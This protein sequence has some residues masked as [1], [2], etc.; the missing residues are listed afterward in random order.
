MG[1]QVTVGSTVPSW[2]YADY[3]PKADEDKMQL[4]AKSWA[5]QATAC[6][7]AAESLGSTMSSLGNSYT[8]PSAEKAQA[9]ATRTR[10]WIGSTADACN[11]LSGQVK[12]AAEYVLF[13]KR[14]MNVVLASLQAATQKATTQAK[15]NVLQQV[16]VA[17]KVRQMQIAARAQIRALNVACVNKIGALTATVDISPDMSAP[18]PAASGSYG[19][20][21]V[22]IKATF[23]SG[24][25]TGLA[26]K[27]D[28]TNA[29][30]TFRLG[31][32]QRTSPNGSL[33][34]GSLSAG[35]LPGGTMPGGTM[36]GGHPGQPGDLTAPAA[37]DLS[38]AD[39]VGGNGA[40]AGVD[41]PPDALGSDGHGADGRRPD[42]TSDPPGILPGGAQVSVADR[43]AADDAVVTGHSHYDAEQAG[44]TNAAA[45]T[46]PG[47]G[48]PTPADTITQAD[49]GGH[50]R[51]D[52]V[53]PAQ[54]SGYQAPPEAPIPTSS[55][56]PSQAP[57]QPAPTYTPAQSTQS[58]TPTHP[59]SVPGYS[60]SASSSTSSNSGSANFSD[61]SYSGGSR[62]YSGADSTSA[63]APAPVPAPAP[64]P[65][66][67]PVHHEPAGTHGAGT[68]APSQP[69]PSQP[70]PTVPSD[71]S[72]NHQPSQGAGNQPSQGA[73]NAVGVSDS[74]AAGPGSNAPGGPSSSGPPS[75]A[76]PSA[77]PPSAAP[78]GSG[79]PVA[80]TG[81]PS[82]PASVGGPI[83]GS[84]PGPAGPSAPAAASAGTS[85]PAVSGPSSSG[86]A[87]GGAP[88]G[89]ATGSGPGGSSGPAV[90]PGSSPGAAPTSGPVGTGG[91][92]T[93][94][95]SGQGTHGPDTHGPGTHGPGTH[96]PDSHGPGTAGPGTEGP[97]TEGPAD[98]TD[99]GPGGDV[100]TTTGPR[101]DQ[102]GVPPGVDQPDAAVEAPIQRDANEPVSPT[103]AD[104]GQTHGA[105][106]AAQSATGLLAVGGLIG[107]GS[108]WADLGRPG[109]GG[110]PSGAGPHGGTIWATQFGAGDQAT[111]VLPAGLSVTYQKVL[112]PSET[113]RFLSLRQRSLRG[114]IYPLD[115][116][117]QL[118][119]PAEL[120]GKLGL[121]FT[122]R[123]G[124]GQPETA[125]PATA[126]HIDVLRFN[127]IRDEDL[128][129]PVEADV[130]PPAQPQIPWVV[131]LHAR[132]W[133]GNGEAPGSLST[134]IIEEFELLAEAG[135]AVPH[136][137][138]IWR[139]FANGE[140]EHVST[141]NARA[142]I[143][144]GD[145]QTVDVGGALVA[146]GM[147]AV[148]TEG[149]QYGAVMVNDHEHVLTWPPRVLVTG[150]EQAGPDG[151]MRIA[152]DNKVLT[153]LLGVATLAHWQ[154][155]RVRL[156]R[157]Y[158]GKSMIDYVGGDPAEAAQ[159]GFRQLGQGE[160]ETRWVPADQVEHRTRMEREYPMP[161]AAEQ[162]AGAIS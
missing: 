123:D 92:P 29:S 41:G 151:M 124:G 37:A 148:T 125:L 67:A 78:P 107:V 36:P 69:A 1:L 40:A 76:P 12:H 122:L 153:R 100:P 102:A 135:V 91:P 10:Q 26:P 143:W 140:S 83:S 84:G 138:E 39:I 80:G 85:G 70:A 109:A 95:P 73:G 142:G 97:G 51:H 65:A 144:T 72:W 96:G 47:D 58:Y 141:Y 89:T 90:T 32:G 74:G 112:L 108:I 154:G 104:D 117:V 53:V 22:G 64:A 126:D 101:G 81:A 28:I 136:L 159:L 60:G 134:A 11:T 25:L 155:A 162:L 115:Q 52:H 116:V 18:S 42:G 44:Q 4:I 114:L 2:V 8:G 152:V 88:P 127:G 98:A 3:F 93:G 57:S 99:S 49:D 6:S 43:A 103:G 94:R 30:N 131:R 63:P 7:R 79:V 19:V 119:T 21:T 31:T 133:A 17:I 130:E 66:P 61:S 59:D 54:D 27:Q 111:A 50:G 145:N 23:T 24:A 110:R 77:A 33:P 129:V 121:G 82:A 9:F 106:G 55:P 113:E 120:H 132:P 139:L 146:N 13:T 62:S 56:A 34:A 160:W 161:R 38:M 128:I 15:R 118:S 137:A 5:Q 68:S 35:S 87:A 46:L 45:R 16:V 86:P 149:E 158:E 71:S 156:L 20:T 75:A 150:S 157:R 48:Q 105:D 147:F 14:A